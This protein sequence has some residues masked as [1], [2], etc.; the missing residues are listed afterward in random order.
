MAPAMLALVM[1]QVNARSFHRCVP[2]TPIILALA[3]KLSSNSRVCDHQ[4]W[5]YN[6]RVWRL[7]I[8]DS[9]AHGGNQP[10]R[11]V[12][13]RDHA[14]VTS[15][16]AANS[17]HSHLC[18]HALVYRS[19]VCGCNTHATQGDEYVE[20]GGLDHGDDINDDGKNDDDDD[21]NTR[22]VVNDSTYRKRSASVVRWDDDDDVG[23]L[24][25]RFCFGGSHV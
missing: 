16:H 11:I 17:D 18:W 8:R 1:M 23:R 14:F 25:T 7:N 19:L 15:L 10:Q 22:D 24:C 6:Y 21:D 4:V 3:S 20:I 5:H 13:A 9:P 12:C 2:A